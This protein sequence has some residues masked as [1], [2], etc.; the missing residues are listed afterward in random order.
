MDP[1][2]AALI[3]IARSG[4]IAG[5]TL[6]QKKL[7]FAA[8]LAE[9]ELGF[10]PHYYGPYSPEVADAV[11]SL[12]ANR[13]LT[14]TTETFPREESIFG[15]WRRHSYELTPDGDR[16]L[17][18]VRQTDEAEKLR[19]ALDKVNAQPIGEDFNLLSIA[20][21]VHILLRKKSPAT[22][23]EIRRMALEYRWQLSEEQI[24]DVAK[25]LVD[26]GLVTQGKRSA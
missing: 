18:A 11:D 4:Q 20:A 1:K 10:R 17:Q 5:R 19:E 16:L 9:Q 21:K 12:V 6:L 26:L 15:E 3:A 8:V 22:A 14:E 7:Y 13:F 2:D 25:Y 24:Q 23:S